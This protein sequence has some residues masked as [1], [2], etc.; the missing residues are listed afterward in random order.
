VR[1]ECQVQ[2]NVIQDAIF[3]NQEVRRQLLINAIFEGDWTGLPTE[4]VSKTQTSELEN[5]DFETSDLENS[6]RLK[7]HLDFKRSSTWMVI[8]LTNPKFQIMRQSRVD[9]WRQLK[10]ILHFYSKQEQRRQERIRYEQWQ[11][12]FTVECNCRK[13][14]ELNSQDGATIDVMHINVR[15][16]RFLLTNTW[17]AEL[18]LS[19]LIWYWSFFQGVWGFEFSKTQTPCKRATKPSKNSSVFETKNLLSAIIGVQSPS[20]IALIKSCRFSSW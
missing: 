7:N 14:K 5:S 3:V 20:K 4:R 18:F 19:L 1:L 11:K 6:D 13:R 16:I 2:Y 12:C 9:N 15:R 17:T 10:G 8:I